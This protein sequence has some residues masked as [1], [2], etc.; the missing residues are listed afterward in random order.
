MI[1]WYEGDF[2]KNFATFVEI[3]WKNFEHRVCVC[4]LRAKFFFFFEWWR[5][6]SIQDTSKSILFQ[7]AH[8]GWIVLLFQFFQF[9]FHPTFIERFVCRCVSIADQSFQMISN[10]AHNQCGRK[11]NPRCVCAH[12]YPDWQHCQ[13]MKGCAKWMSNRSGLICD[14]QSVL[15]RLIRKKNW[16]IRWFILRSVRLKTWFRYMIMCTL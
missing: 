6:I 4:L 3:G 16:L 14:N 15:I 10:C 7:W 12:E 9:S 13:L 2:G 11:H 8:F 1:E 5:Q